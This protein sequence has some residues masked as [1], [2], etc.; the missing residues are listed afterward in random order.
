MYSSNTVTY[1]VNA[2]GVLTVN[3]Y[4]ENVVDE[5]HPLQTPV[6]L[7]VPYH[8][9]WEADARKWSSDCGPATVEM[10]GEFYR[11]E[12]IT[13]TDD[14]ME[15]I[16]GGTNKLTSATD[17]VN[18][19]DHFYAVKLSKRYGYSWEELVKEYEAGHP[20]IV[21]VHYGAFQM[22]LD[23]GFTGGHWMVVTGFDTVDYQGKL[24]ERIILH[25]PDWWAPWLEQGEHMPVTKE[26]FE[27]MWNE[28]YKDNNPQ[29]MALTSEG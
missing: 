22:R 10:V 14:I 6:T 16:T 8:S 1:D 11:G 26:H 13:S 23:R 20:T 5:P 9:Q 7:T 17:L 12:Q 28:A 27:R 24:V 2:D 15:F 4:P 3:F 21:L 29:R 19:A 25:D 18:A